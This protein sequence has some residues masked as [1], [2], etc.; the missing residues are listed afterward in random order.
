MRPRVPGDRPQRQG[1]GGCEGLQRAGQGRRSAPVALQEAGLNVLSLGMGTDLL[2]SPG[3]RGSHST[4]ENLLH[5][6]TGRSPAAVPG[7]KKTAWTLG[8]LTE[9]PQRHI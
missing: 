3:H 6:V 5:Q 1:A 7:G 2:R 9:G 8:R 4:W